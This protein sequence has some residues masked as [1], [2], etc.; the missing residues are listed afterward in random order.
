MSIQTGRMVDINVPM[1]VLL[2]IRDYP[3]EKVASYFLSVVVLVQ[4][5]HL[6]EQVSH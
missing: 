3:L 4:I 5:F 1:A 2:I 6:L